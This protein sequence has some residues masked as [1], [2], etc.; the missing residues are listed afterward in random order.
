[1]LDVSNDTGLYKMFPIPVRIFNMNFG[2]VITKFNDTNFMKG[3]DAS[4][5]QA[6][7]QS[8]H[9]IVAKNG[10]QWNKCTSSGRDN[11]N[12]NIGNGN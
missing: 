5:T 2:R 4:T 1:M 6:L 11:T 12:T 10:V 7:F 8:I 9:D 3:W